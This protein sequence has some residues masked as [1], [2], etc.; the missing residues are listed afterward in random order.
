MIE[1]G[2]N[3]RTYR[4]RE[5]MTVSEWDT[6]KKSI[7]SLTVEEAGFLLMQQNLLDS[8]GAKYESVEAIKAVLPLPDVDLIGEKIWEVN[9]IK[10]VAKP[11]DGKVE[12]SN[13]GHGGEDENA[14]L[15]TSS[16]SA[17]G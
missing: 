9:K 8:S 2:V 1:F 15:P 12:E 4:I 17:E 10:L 13:S 7:A 6:F 11:A 16:D 14:P 5:Y 3:G